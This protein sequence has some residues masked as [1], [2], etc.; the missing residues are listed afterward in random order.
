MTVGDAIASFLRHHPSQFILVK[1]AV[2]K[3]YK[4]ELVPATLPDEALDLIIDLKVNV[5]G[6]TAIVATRLDLESGHIMLCPDEGGVD[7]LGVQSTPPNRIVGYR[8]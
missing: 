6:R 7:I 3:A 1:P 4:R 2:A 8:I 5:R